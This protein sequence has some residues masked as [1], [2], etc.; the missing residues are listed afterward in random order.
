MQMANR[1]MKKCS[2]LLMLMEM[3]NKTTVR[4]HFTPARWLLSKR[5]E[6]TSVVKDMEK[7]ESVCTVDGYVNWYNHCRKQYG[8]S[9]KN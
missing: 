6:I 5:E 7:R 1:Y 4:Y 9:S 8:V 3:Q 2:E